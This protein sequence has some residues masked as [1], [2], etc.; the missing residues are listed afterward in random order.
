ML[1]LMLIAMMAVVLA[2]DGALSLP[3][4]AGL[5]PGLVALLTVGS[6]AGLIAAQHIALVI[7]GRGL[8]RG[9]S[10]RFVSAAEKVMG[11]TR[12][13]ALALHIA[14]VVALGWLDAVRSLLGGN[15]IAVDE[16]LAAAPPVIVVV[17]GW[18]SYY[19]IDRRLRE[20]SLIGAL[21]AGDYTPSLPTRWQYV[22][23]Q[24]R[25]QVLL[26]VVPVALIAAWAEGVDR[27]VAL[28]P[29][30]WSDVQTWQGGAVSTV[31]HLVGVVVA[32]VCMP[33][34]IRVL[35][36][37]V[38][39]GAGALRDR[40]LAMCAAQGVRCRDLLVWR[41][42]SRMLNG[43]VIGMVPRLR[44]I[45][46]TDTLLE[47]LS[48][49]QVEAVMAHELA[50]ARRHHLPWLMA[51]IIATISLSWTASVWGGSLIAG[52]LHI[53]EFAVVIVG[54]AAVLITATVTMLGF[55]WVS[56]RFEQ[57]ADAFAA[58]HLSGRNRET[59]ARR[60]MVI[61]A[62]AAIAMASALGLVARRNHIAREAFSFRHGSIASR[63]RNIERLV[64][65]PA[66]RL[67]VDRVVMGIKVAAV[68][69]VAI[70]I[71]LA[72]LGA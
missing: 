57:Q 60:D 45:L 1:H 41:T 8:D 10:W 30:P 47:S 42:H 32:L 51:T 9:G 56:R 31:S 34:I 18:F 48:E 63:Q 5:R 21:D 26:V 25:F 16:L 3:L 22:L 54:G 58:Q 50:H 29:E 24:T 19:A 44:F 39:L 62:P 28:L 61:T 27:V 35:W 71:V 36:D 65:A 11:L 69:G 52:A 68:V 33:L 59:E 4:L 49:E 67:P 70:T 23:D 37:T 7:C 64:G 20:A 15:W 55:G 72:L 12:W 40:L 66:H 46:L 2:R 13:I 6:M 53:E 17:S 14:A 43:A 38:P